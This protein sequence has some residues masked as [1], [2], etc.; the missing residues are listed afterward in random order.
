MNNNKN[1]N[2]L[3]ITIVTC[4]VFVV[5]T[6]SI[7]TIIFILQNKNNQDNNLPNIPDSKPDEKPNP[8]IEDNKK[9]SLVILNDNTLI[10]RYLIN[11]SIRNVNDYF[12]EINSVLSLNDI[13]LKFNNVLF[14]ISSKE[15]FNEEVNKVL[16]RSENLNSNYYKLTFLIELK[17]NFIFDDGQ[18]KRTTIINF[19]YS[20]P[21]ELEAPNSN[22]RTFFES[23]DNQ[24]DKFGTKQYSLYFPKLT[25]VNSLG[26][27]EKNKKLITNFI[28]RYFETKHQDFLLRQEWIYQFNVICIC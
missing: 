24:Q 1:K 23:F 21:P 25:N 14:F 12:G 3:I 27:E 8:P 16:F 9:T 28:E 2:F 15:K 6:I 11:N 22:Y 7:P 17:N 4:F 10:K 13:W 5:T 18:N 19:D 20:L 26:S